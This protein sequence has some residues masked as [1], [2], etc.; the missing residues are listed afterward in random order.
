MERRDPDAEQTAVH[1]NEERQATAAQDASESAAEYDPRS[2]ATLWT[3]FAGAAAML[4]VAGWI[5]AR[6]GVSIAA[7]TGVSESVVGGLFT[8]IS[9]SL[10]ELVTAIA[11]VHH[12]ALTLAVGDIIGG[13]AFDT[14][15]AAIS[16]VFYR[17]G[18]IYHAV[19]QRIVFRRSVR[20]STLELEP[21]QTAAARRFDSSRNSCVCEPAHRVRLALEHLAPTSGSHRCSHTGDGGDADRCQSPIASTP[22][23]GS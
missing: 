5:I 3:L 12:G 16:D 21:Q 17:E 23:R 15:F 20:A 22:V 9:T 1:R 8:A 6:S 4:V 13:N 2:T 7:G 19:S 10:P 18:S 11:A 14:L